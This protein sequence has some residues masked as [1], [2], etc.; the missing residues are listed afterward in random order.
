MLYKV[1]DFAEK[2]AADVMVPRPDVVG[3]ADRAAPE[4]AMRRCSSRRT[5][6]IRCSAESL[7]DIVGILHIR[8]L[9]AALEDGRSAATS[10]LESLL[11]SGVRRARDE[12]PRRPAQRVPAARTSTWRSSSTSTA[13]RP[14]SS[15]SRTCS[16][17]SSATSRT[18]ST[19]RTSRSSGSTTRRIRIDGSFTIDDFNEQFGTEIDDEDFHTVAG[20]VFGHLGRAAEVGDEVV[21]DQL[22]I[23]RARDER[24]AHPAARGRVPARRRRGRRH[25][26]SRLTGARSATR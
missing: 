6:A 9:V 21:E 1:F 8:A 23:P 16:R 25:A 18:S 2:E 7:D 3:L 20:F 24:L 11:H 12:G 19:S 5:P 17:R 15:R 22:R 13:R 26:G 4:E 10:Q 14:A